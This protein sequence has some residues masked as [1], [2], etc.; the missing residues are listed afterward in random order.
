M[1]EKLQ[2]PSDPA[3]FPVWFWVSQERHSPAF[4]SGEE[5]AGSGLRSPLR[6]LRAPH[7]R[8]PLPFQDAH[9]R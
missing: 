1:K 9:T 3:A 2:A 7:G 5:A 4:G 6:P 8:D